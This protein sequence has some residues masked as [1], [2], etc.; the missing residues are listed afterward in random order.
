[1]VWGCIVED[2]TDELHFN[3]SWLHSVLVM[4]QRMGTVAVTESEQMAPSWVGACQSAK[5]VPTGGVHHCTGAPRPANHLTGI[6]RSGDGT[7]LGARL[8]SRPKQ[9]TGDRTA[10]P[11]LFTF[12][13]FSR[14][15]YLR[16]SSPAGSQVTILSLLLLHMFMLS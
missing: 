10:R 1:M 3:N 15:Y 12:F 9:T 14:A 2:G 5:E 7:H 8:P 11:S 4:I 13:S 16:A 6:T